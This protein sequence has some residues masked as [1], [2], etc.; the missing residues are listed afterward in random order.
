MKLSDEQIKSIAEEL[1]CGMKV[2]VHIETKEMK[3]ILDFND[4]FYMDEEEWAEEI[5]EI[6]ENYDKYVQFEKMD[7]RESFR[8]MDEFIETVKDEKL[9]MKLELGLS[10]SKPFRNFKDIIDSAGEYREKWFEFKSMKY[11]EYVKEQL[12]FLNN[13][14]E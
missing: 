2:Y 9:K 11:V 7:S 4:N 10:L 8:V 1:E 3:T 6:E 12:A 14:G 5:K 13:A